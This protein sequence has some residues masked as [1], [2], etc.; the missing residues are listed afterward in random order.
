MRETRICCDRCG[1][2]VLQPGA[3]LEV[4]A[5]DIRV[6][7]SEPLDWC[8]DW[9]SGSRTGC[10]LAKNLTSSTRLASRPDWYRPEATSI[11]MERSIPASRVL[12]TTGPRVG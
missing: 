10:D 8:G 5:G 1:A 12:T 9:H 11:G 6:Q 4:K 2:V 7:Y 3:V